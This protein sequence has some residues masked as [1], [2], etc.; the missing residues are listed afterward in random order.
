MFEFYARI[1]GGDLV[2]SVSH[3]ILSCCMILSDD[4]HSGDSGFA[5]QMRSGAIDLPRLYI[6]WPNHV[7]VNLRN[8]Y[9]IF[10]RADIG[11]LS[12]C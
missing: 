4:R 5:W 8:Y 1:W 9:L 2:R 11:T 3:Q 6:S 10:P 12:I 7:S